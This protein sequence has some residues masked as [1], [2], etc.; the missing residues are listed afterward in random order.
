MPRLLLLTPF[1]LS[2]PAGVIAYDY[3]NYSPPLERL[4]A[5]NSNNDTALPRHLYLRSSCSSIPSQLTSLFCFKYFPTNLNC[6][7]TGNSLFFRME[8]TSTPFGPL[9]LF[10]LFVSS[11]FI[12]NGLCAKSLYD[13]KFYFWD[14][15]AVLELLYKWLRNDF[16]GQNSEDERLASN[17]YSLRREIY[18]KLGG[19][20]MFFSPIAISNVERFWSGS[21]INKNKAMVD[22]LQHYGIISSKKVAEVMETIDRALFVPDGTLAYV[23]SPMAIGYNATIS[24]PHMHA[25]CLQLLE[26]N[27]KPGMHA[28]DVGS[29]F[30]L[31]QILGNAVGVVGGKLVLQC[32]TL[33][34]FEGTGYLTA[35]FALMVGPQGRAIGVEHIPELANSSLKNIEKSAAAPLLKE[36][37]LSIHVGDGRQGW[38]E[39]APYDAIHVGAAAPEIPQPLLDQLKPGGR[40]VIPVGNIFQD[41]KVVDKKEDGSISVRSET[42]VR[43]VPL[44]S[45]DAQLRG[46]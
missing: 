7:I 28:L 17:H 42:S 4:L 22:H 46:Y 37:S 13:L 9:S 12:S 31:I 23:D 1:S 5:H 34:I 39:F 10:S 30:Q 24:A 14:I 8:V 3:R 29:G 15:A 35:C 45:R 2:L 32:F 40:M 38:P 11:L 25:T 43:Y 36:G 20:T 27:L 19:H 16:C 41:L 18:F 21:S 33:F 26:E 44:T 6:T